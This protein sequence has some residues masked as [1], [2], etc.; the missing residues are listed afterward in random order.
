MFSTIAQ[1]RIQARQIVTLQ[2]SLP[3][4]TA[5]TPILDSSVG[6]GLALLHKKESVLC[7]ERVPIEHQ[8]QR[9]QDET[10]IPRPQL[11]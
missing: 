9:Q 10:A 1:E 3:R 8:T 2:D 7:N 11:E 5:T 4:Q 6:L